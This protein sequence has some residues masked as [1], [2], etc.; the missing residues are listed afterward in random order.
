MEQNHCYEVFRD[1]DLP[2]DDCLMQKALAL[3]KIQRFEFDTPSGESFQ[4]TYTPFVDSNGQN[5]VVI[6]RRD[7]SERKTSMAMAISSERLAALGELAAGVAH[8]IN[9]P[10]NG[11][12]NYAQILVNKTNKEDPLNTIANRIIGE[13]DRIA[14]I[15]ASLLSFSRRDNEKCYLVS[16]RE[17]LEESLTL[18]GAQLKQDGITLSINMA[19]NLLPISAIGQEIEQ[20]FLNIINNSRYALNDKYPRSE[21]MKKLEIDVRVVVSDNGNIVVRTCFTDYGTGIQAN[22]LEKVDNP[23]F[24]T[25][26]KGK[27]TGLG[28]TISH[29]IVEKH[30]G[31]IAI[32]SIA[33]EYTKVT[34]EFPA[35]YSKKPG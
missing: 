2:C 35:Q 10:I 23:F 1:K 18:T 33:G 28:L 12:I 17:L 4:H 34:V 6:S 21:D 26:P 24:S 14:G 13:G 8:E 3:G 16:I 27:G 22:L 29:R 25:K 7:I 31:K 19:D 20:V 11:I 15:V 32:D 5:K 9:N 30:N